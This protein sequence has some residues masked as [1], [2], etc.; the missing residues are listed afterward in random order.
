MEVS[1]NDCPIHDVVVYSDRA[2]VKRVVS[3]EVPDGESTI[4]VKD[5]SQ[6]ADKDSIR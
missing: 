5:L 3:V 6:S 1:I 2:E 4:V